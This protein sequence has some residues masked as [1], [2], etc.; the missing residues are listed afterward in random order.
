[1]SAPKLFVTK[2]VTIPKATIEFPASLC[3]HRY[4]FNRAAPFGTIT[5]TIGYYNGTPDIGPGEPFNTQ[6]ALKV[7]F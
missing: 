7:L 3:M 6:F 2:R 5:Q 4:L 1:V